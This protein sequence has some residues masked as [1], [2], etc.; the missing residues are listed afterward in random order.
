MNNER[1]EMVR[2]IIEV[3][4][5][6]LSLGTFSEEELGDIMNYLCTT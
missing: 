2:E 5:D 6:Q 3:R 4:S 1:I